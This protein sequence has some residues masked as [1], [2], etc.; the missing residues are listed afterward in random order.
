[1]SRSSASPSPTSAAGAVERVLVLGVGGAQIDAL[2]ALR[3]RGLE[4]HALG[5]RDAGAGRAVAD[6]FAVID[7]AD[8]EAVTDY[9]RRARVGAVYSIGSDVAMPAVATASA[10]LG[11]PGFLDP[12]ISAVLRDK[13]K[14]RTRL[15]RR[16]VG[17]L[18]FRTVREPADIANWDIYP[19]ILKP[20]DSQGQR[21]VHKLEDP[22]DFA[23]AFA[24]AIAHSRA[25]RLIIE[26]YV[27]GPELSVNVYLVAGAVCFL[28]TTSRLIHADYPGGLVWRHLIPASGGSDELTRRVRDLV[29]RT[30]AALDL[31]DGPVYLQIKLRDGEPRLIEV[32]ARLDG[33]HLW[34]LVALATG[35][36][37]LEATLSHLLNG[38]PRDGTL[39]RTGPPRSLA[40][41]FHSVP[42]GTIFKRMPAPPNAL[43]TEWYYEDGEQVLPLNGYYE[44]VG[45]SIHQP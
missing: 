42:P 4:V 26:D 28:Q 22:T 18:A 20:V 7:I 34:R 31:R 21:G 14:V 8:A 30:V 5:Y 33:C 29:S 10:R 35:A 1:M 44:K 41:T 36:D 23:D 16:F 38:T 12:E 43:H 45:Y 27:A 15:G 13:D 17:N 9:A 2:R 6:H 11:L 24:N 25:G 32:A 19:A 3:D 39:N 40:L 37:L